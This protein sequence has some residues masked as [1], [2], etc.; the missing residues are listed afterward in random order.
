M[1]EIC[2]VR[3]VWC[4]AQAE[5]VERLQTTRFSQLTAPATALAQLAV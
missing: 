1:N 2:P 4:K 5:L 3:S